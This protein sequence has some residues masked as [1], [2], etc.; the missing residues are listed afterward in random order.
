VTATLEKA[1]LMD[2]LIFFLR[3]IHEFSKLNNFN[4]MA[5]FFFGIR[6]SSSALS[7]IQN[8]H[9]AYQQIYTSTDLLFSDKVNHKRYRE[10]LRNAPVLCIP[11]VTVFLEDLQKIFSKLLEKE[12]IVFDR[13]IEATNIIDEFTRYQIRTEKI[14]AIPCIQK[15]LI[16]LEKERNWN[17]LIKKDEFMAQFRGEAQSLAANFRT[18]FQN[19]RNTLNLS[20]NP[21][22]VKFYFTKGK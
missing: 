17:A 4:G 16:G 12:M 6:R 10:T 13:C 8:L 21:S 5:E 2:E 22:Q 7:Q 19:F 9:P 20:I 18:K 14:Q 1:T 11:F 15:W 3:V